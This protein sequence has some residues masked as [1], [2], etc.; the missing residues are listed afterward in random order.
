[1]P[2]QPEPHCPHAFAAPARRARSA[3]PGNGRES[4]APSR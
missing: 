1:M 3:K 2:D 4:M